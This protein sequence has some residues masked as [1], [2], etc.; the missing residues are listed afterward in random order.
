[1]A[2]NLGPRPGDGKGKETPPRSALDPL[3]ITQLLPHIVVVD[4]MREPARFRY[5]LIGTVLTGLAGR[6]AT[7]RFLN[8]ALYGRF[9]E[10]MIWPYQKVVE[11]GAPV[12]TLSGILF[13]ERDWHCI[14]NM[15]VPFGE[16]GQI[17]VIAVCADA[18]R[19]KLQRD[20]S[21]GLVLDWRG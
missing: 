14:E 18:D 4:V 16:G 12:A 15:F 6:D 7:G 1:M 5:R 3:E 8:R 13:T 9:L 17:D 10:A 11:T 20:L 2:P 19:N 21:Q